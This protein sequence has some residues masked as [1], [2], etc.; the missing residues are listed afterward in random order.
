MTIDKQ[1]YI[2]L[3][4]SQYQNSTK[5]LNWLS[6]LFQPLEDIASCAEGMD[7]KFDL[8]SAIG[9]Q[10]DVCGRIVGLSRYIAYPVYNTDVGFYWADFSHSPPL[11][12]DRGWD[13]GI[14]MVKTQTEILSLPDDTYRQAIKIRLAMNKWNGSIK[15]LYDS[16][17]AIFG[18]SIHLAIVNNT[19]MSMDFLMWGADIT[20]LTP[21]L[22]ESGYLSFVP[23]G[24]KV[25][26]YINDPEYPYPVMS[27]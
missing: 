8:D 18:G 7:A 5:F 23:A 15:D 1:D 26:Y 20:I 27:P 14:W 6:E 12:T 16:W 2:S 24:V 3:I 19:N 11:Y 9:S 10:L 21:Y 4:T 17:D 25:T 13:A 22:F